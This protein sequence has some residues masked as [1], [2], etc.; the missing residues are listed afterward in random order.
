MRRWGEFV[1]R[2]EPVTRSPKDLRRRPASGGRRP[3]DPPAEEVP[4]AEVPQPDAPTSARRLRYLIS[5]AGSPNYGDEL[6]T[7]GW[8]RRLAESCPDDDVV[9]DCP[10]PAGAQALFWSDHPRLRCV[11]TVFRLCWEAPG[12]NVWETASFVTAALIDHGHVPRWIPGLRLLERADTVHLLGG[13]YANDVWPRNTGVFA[14]LAW[15]ARRGTPTAITGQGLLPSADQHRELIAALVDTLGIVDLRDAGSGEAIGRPEC[16]SGDDLWMVDLA[17]LVDAERA[18]GLDG[19]L[20]LQSDIAGLSEESMVTRALRAVGAWDVDPGRVAVVECIPR[21]DRV[22]FDR[23]W[24]LL[25]G[26]Q[27]VSWT[28][29]LERGLPARAGQQWLSSRFHPHMVAARAGAGGVALD[30]RP[31][32]YDVKHASLLAAGSPWRV[33][34]ENGETLERRPD[35]DVGVFR[36]TGEVIAARKEQ[37][38]RELY[39]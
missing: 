3:D 35:A 11:D 23:L 13:G 10:H 1:A 26:I 20:C 21:V 39:A 36:A 27:F 5:V 8:L 28:D 19:L 25:P 14:A 22:V 30:V 17:E 4:L 31:G 2:G 34:G 6:I 24:H 18:E 7:R 37:I 15:L 9:L 16:V 33:E 32:Y 38:F 29:A 12:D